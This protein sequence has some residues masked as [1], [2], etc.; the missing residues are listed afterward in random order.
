MSNFAKITRL[1]NINNGD[2]IK[3]FQKFVRSL[4]KFF[5]NAKVETVQPETLKV[6]VPV[7][8]CLQGSK[9]TD[10]ST[11]S[12]FRTMGKKSNHNIFNMCWS[13]SSRPPSVVHQYRSC[14]I[15]TEPPFV[16]DIPYPT[17]QQLYTSRSKEDDIALYELDY[18][19]E[20]PISEYEFTLRQDNVSEEYSDDESTLREGMVSPDLFSEAST[21]INVRHA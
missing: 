8:Q 17:A 6:T 21:V 2:R 20:L 12:R 7:P 18:E 10:V 13:S 1:F 5:K 15:Q 11:I 14:G 19:E 9:E 3:P 16:A 4:S